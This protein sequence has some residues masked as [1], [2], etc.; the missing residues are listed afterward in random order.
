MLKKDRKAQSIELIYISL[1]LTMQNSKTD[2]P[3]VM[4]KHSIS[5]QGD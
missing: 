1:T 2:K 3:V 5:E 4:M